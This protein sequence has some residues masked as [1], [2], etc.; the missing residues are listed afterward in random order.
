M[1]FQKTSDR[2]IALD[3]SVDPPSMARCV[4]L[5]MDQGFLTRAVLPPQCAMEDFGGGGGGGRGCIRSKGAEG[6]RYA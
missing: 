4:L 2:Y 5:A 3:C 1:G 6:G